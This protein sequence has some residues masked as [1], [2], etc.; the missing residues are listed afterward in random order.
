MTRDGDCW[1]DESI[2]DACACAV[3]FRDAI[4]R[5]VASGALAGTAISSFPRGCCG[6][7]SDL[8]QRYFKE[9]GIYSC[10]VCGTF[11]GDTA[12][13]DQSHAWLELPDGTVVDITGD[14]F[15]L[16]QGPLHNELKVY[17]GKPNAFYSS[18]GRIERFDFV[19]SASPSVVRKENEMYEIVCRYLH[20]LS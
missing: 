10:Y 8:L 4:D 3:A 11:S 13:D 12:F 5:A 1:M 6:Y 15:R 2:S 20:A 9:H 17:C 18:F 19:E 7:A 14:Q 16:A